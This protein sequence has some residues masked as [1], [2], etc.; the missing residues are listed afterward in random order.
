MF[1]NTIEGPRE[2]SKMPIE[3]GYPEKRRGH[4]PKYEK[5]CENPEFQNPKY[6]TR[7][8]V[9]YIKYNIYINIEDGE[10]KCEGGR[11]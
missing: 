8:H 10:R 7:I 6:L 3:V 4:L 1:G 2:Y 9:Q 11:M 5:H